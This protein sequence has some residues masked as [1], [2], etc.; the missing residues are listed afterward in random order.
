MNMTTSQYK[1]LSEKIIDIYG[2]GAMGGTFG[3]KDKDGDYVLPNGEKLKTVVEDIDN[4]LETVKNRD[5]TFCSLP[6]NYDLEYG[7]ENTDYLMSKG[8]CGY[9]TTDKFYHCK[10]DY[11]TLDVNNV[12]TTTT[13]K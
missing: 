1:D 13:I 2:E 8:Y 4:L 6:I 5:K 11:E 7:D 10:I 3:K 9:C 12:T